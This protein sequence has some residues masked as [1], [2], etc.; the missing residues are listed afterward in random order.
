[1]E[2]IE[3]TGCIELSRFQ[4]HVNKITVYEF[5]GMSIENLWK[6]LS[7]TLGAADFCY[8]KSK[9]YVCILHRQNWGSHNLLF[10][11]LLSCLCQAFF[12]VENPGLQLIYNKWNPAIYIKKEIKVSFKLYSFKMPRKRAS[13]LLFETKLE[14]W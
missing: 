13:I 12:Y 8:L 5:L 9:Q 4:I 6:S 2:K 11:R 3:S 14:M 10:H 7:S 1:M